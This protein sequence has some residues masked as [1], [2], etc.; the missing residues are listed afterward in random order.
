MGYFGNT[1]DANEMRRKMIEELNFP[2]TL[3]FASGTIKTAQP[4]FTAIAAAFPANIKLTTLTSNYATF[5]DGA[6]M[7]RIVHLFSVGE[8]P[9]L[10]QPA[11]IS[12]ADIFSKAG[13]AIGSI[14]ETT[15]TGNQDKAEWEAKK[16]HWDTSVDGT[17][18][19]YV[20]FDAK[21]GDLSVTLRPMEVRT[22]L[23]VFQ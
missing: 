21:A 20:P 13:L 12:L 17:A 23:A 3:A 16:Y 22:F 9:T 5:N 10:S 18:Q 6:C 14:R 19:P 8:H 2:P 15:L 7:L 11:T 1:E 4:S